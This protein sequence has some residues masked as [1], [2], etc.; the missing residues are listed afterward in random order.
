M[1]YNQQRLISHSLQA[2]SKISVPVRSDGGPLPGCTPPAVPSHGEGLWGYGGL[3]ITRSPSSPSKPIP[4]A[5]PHDTITLGLQGTAQEAEGDSNVQMTAL[6]KPR[7]KVRQAECVAGQ[8]M[9]GSTEGSND[10]IGS[11]TLLLK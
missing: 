1:A 10:K 11:R 9:A 3:F 8:L 6:M 7:R 2:K 4:K 5:P